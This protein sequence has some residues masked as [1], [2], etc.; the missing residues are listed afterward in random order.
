ML[1]ISSGAPNLT[2]HLVA[3]TLDMTGGTLTIGTAGAFLLN[4]ATGNVSNA[5]VNNAGALSYQGG[6]SLQFAATATLNNSGNIDVPNGEILLASTNSF[7]DGS[8]LTGGGPGVGLIRVTNGGSFNGTITSDSLRL[9]GGAYSGTATFAGTTELG[10]RHITGAFTVPAAVYVQSDRD[11]LEDDREL[12]SLTTT[13][14]A[15][16]CF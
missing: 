7:T 8:G 4:G 6:G 11:E 5:T 9:E 12:A 1:T 10:R 13:A 15:E 2:G 14:A 16:S 3:G